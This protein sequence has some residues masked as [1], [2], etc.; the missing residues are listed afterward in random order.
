MLKVNYKIYG[1]G[2]PFLLLHGWGSSVERWAKIAEEISKKGYKV[3]VVDMPGFGKSDV[4]ETAWRIDDYIAWLEKFLK[5]QPGFGRSFILLG[6]SFGGT[7]SS[8][9]SVKNP[10]KIKKLFLVSSAGVRKK[11]F[12]KTIL[13]DIAHFLNNFK[14]VPLY[15]FARKVFYKYFVG[16]TDYLTV[17]ES[18]KD[19][20]LKVISKDFSELIPKISVPT[21]II[22][23][24]KDNVTLLEDAHYHE[25][26]IKGSK[27]VIIPNAGHD[28]NIKQPEILIKKILNNL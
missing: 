15:G 11:T 10:K 7:L 12:K 25:K 5:T 9:Y 16:R 19:T 13:A 22:W 27:L 6:H 8:I 4:P 23:G 17:K 14:D 2:K 18:M 26:C 3:L 1:K 20:Y 21:V 24:E 28:L